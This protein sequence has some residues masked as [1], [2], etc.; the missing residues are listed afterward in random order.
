[1]SSK[2]TVTIWAWNFS[3]T[4]ANSRVCTRCQPDGIIVTAMLL[5]NVIQFI[6]KCYFYGQETISNIFYHFCFCWCRRSDIVHYSNSVLDRGASFI[7]CTGDVPQDASCSARSSLVRQSRAQ[8]SWE[9]DQRRNVDEAFDAKE[10]SLL[11]FL[12]HAQNSEYQV[13]FV[14]K[15]RRGRS[16]HSVKMAIVELSGSSDDELQP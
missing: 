7:L 10:K 3:M 1:M 4:R 12:Q 8:P 6:E 13:V 16:L 11:Q 2:P 5:T 15:D 9:R 14:G